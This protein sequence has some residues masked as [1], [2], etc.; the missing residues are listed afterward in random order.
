T[1]AYEFVGQGAAPKAFCVT[2]KCSVLQITPVV[3]GCD[4]NFNDDPVCAITNQNI[5]YQTCPPAAGNP[6][7]LPPCVAGNAEPINSPLTYS[8]KSSDSSSSGPDTCTVAANKM[9]PGIYFEGGLDLTALGL[10][11][12]CTSTFTMDT[13]SSGSVDAS[14]QDLAIGQLGSCTSSL[15]TTPKNGAGD[16]TPPHAQDNP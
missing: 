11:G 5:K 4:P 8:E 1:T 6:P 7:V 2:S 3:S 10:G 13:R 12:E 14:L 16:P 9:C 15:S